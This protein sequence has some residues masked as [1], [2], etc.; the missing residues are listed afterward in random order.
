MKKI[1]DKV[2]LS[3][4][5]CGLKF[6]NPFILSSAPPTGSCTMIRRAF[7][8]G[9]AGAVIKTMVF[10][11]S[12]VPR[13]TFSRLQFEEKNM[14]VL[15]NFELFTELP[16]KY[17]LPEIKKTKRDYP[18]KILIGSI[19]A[20]SDVAK[21]QELARKVQGAGVDAIELN[22]SCPNTL[23]GE[24]MGASIGTDPKTTGLVVKCVKEA[25]DVPVIA[26][27]TPNVTD[28]AEIA[29]AAERNGADLLSAINTVQGFVGVDLETMQPKPVIDGLSAFGGC[30]GPAVKPI[31]LRC[32]AQ[33][34]K[35][36]KL[37]IFGIGGIT[38]W[39]DAAEFLMVGASALQVCTA[40]MFNGYRIVDGFKDGLANYLA[41]K[42]F[43]SVKDIV[44]HILPKLTQ[45]EKL[46]TS[47][48]INYEIDKNKCIRCGR[49]YLACRDGGY[50]A[51]KLDEEVLPTINEEKC[52]VCS[53]CLNVCPVWDCIKP[54]VKRS[55]TR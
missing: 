26:K 21:W 54:K 1:L 39:Q 46:S 14:I 34:A 50:D 51:I 44:G 29:Q 41:E 47:P 28:I 33:M 53:L 11:P 17:W 4:E 9:W 52:Q 16:L 7:D 24:K 55:A 20:E 30:S 48:K 6:E 18:D 22:I 38:T 37:P 10:K 3:T 19:A 5:L 35:A 45:V 12:L 25:V 8:I 27:L 42:G 23:P 15:Q 43:D 2:D 31:A 40:V 36:T 49:C 13:P 32:V